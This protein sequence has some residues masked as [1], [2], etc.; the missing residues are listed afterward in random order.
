MEK[1]I[2]KTGR[3]S[4]GG[5]DPFFYSIQLNSVTLSMRLPSTIT[6]GS[7]RASVFGGGDH[8]LPAYIIGPELGSAMWRAF[9]PREA[10]ARDESNDELSCL[11]LPAGGSVLM[12]TGQSGDFEL[13]AVSVY[14]DDLQPPLTGERIYENIY[15]QAER[16]A[17]ERSGGVSVPGAAAAAELPE[18][19]VVA[20]LPPQ[21]PRR[22]RADVGD[23]PA[24]A[25]QASPAASPAA[26]R[27]PAAVQSAA[28]SP[29]LVPALAPA[30]QRSPRRSPFAAQ[31]SASSRIRKKRR[32]NTLSKCERDSLRAAAE[33]KR[34]AAKAT[35][36]T[37]LRAAQSG[38][39]SW[40][41]RK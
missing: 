31:Q 22:P 30:A 21:S 9:V 33:K 6:W 34:A 7:A 39:A 16:D 3:A 37:D 8:A 19:P 29:A 40:L 13:A 12:N 26:L 15:T 10:T 35:A 2:R 32:V 38:M 4:V 5:L 28:P 14:A 17:G 41:S 1:H 11:G 27:R 36:A 25:S 18:L 23:S 24:P 20:A